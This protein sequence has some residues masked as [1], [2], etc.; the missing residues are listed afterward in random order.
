MGADYRQYPFGKGHHPAGWVETT[1]GDVVLEFRSGYSSGK[2]NQT[3]QGIPHLR[4]MNVSPVG[5]IL[6]EDVRYVSP[7]VRALRLAKND[8]LFTNTSSTAW[9]G[10]TALVQ[11]PGDW[12]F[13]NHMTRLRVADGM[14]PEFVARQL[15]YLCINGY[16]AFHCKKHI[17]QSS[18]AGKQLAENV[19]F[20]LPPANEQKR[21]ASK[22][23]RLLVRE[24]RL[25]EE[26]DALPALIQQ[27]RAA[28]L[29]AACMGR[30][31][32]TE[33]ELARKERREF[34]PASVL[35]ERL[36]VER[37]SKWEVD[38]LAKMRAAG[39][40][41]KDDKWKERYSAPAAS[42][43][44]G[45]SQIPDGWAWAT[46]DG[47][48]E[49]PLCNGISIAGSDKPPGVPALRLS[50]M[51]DSGFNYEDVRYLPLSEAEIDDLW[52]HE[53]DYF[54]SRGSGSPAL[55]GRGTLAQKPP[56]K[57]IFPDTM[58]RLRISRTIRGANWLP[59]IWRSN[60]VRQQ[61]SR[62][63]KTTAGI[64]KIS[65]PTVQTI[66][67]PLPPI[68]EQQRIVAEVEQRLAAIDRIEKQILAALEQTS[69]LRIALFHRSLS[70]KFIP[71]S[72]NDEAA[73]L[74]LEKIT[75]AKKSRLEEQKKEAPK[76]M[77]RKTPIPASRLDLLEV[78]NSHAE[79]L[80]PEELMAE[81]GYA[82]D[83]VP[84]FYQALRKL[85]KEILEVRPERK[86]VIL[87]RR[88]P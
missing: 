65:Q 22:L 47:L 13:S 41:P 67:I 24:R 31:V 50:A 48:I 77:K 16:F 63:A 66:S 71:Q 58:I 53:G 46:V 68:A 44:S 62:R 33:A 17:N 19:P 72:T 36:L 18:V 86:V 7:R 10:K 45:V 12:G 15:H 39:K 25:R 4:P 55:V 52:I 1:V 49:E 70:G 40:E 81:S 14:S 76:A 87:K 83:E 85:E 2:H 3:G 43:L 37:R 27:Y 75:A 11:E 84:A 80:T 9:V 42:H 69:Q 79:G 59:T 51:G 73:S 78:L 29:E 8:V 23:R 20:R 61:V 56:L 74:L 5:E 82:S 34:E 88:R 26:L 38:Q 54:L 57:V 28:V 32:P 35:L 6:M 21:I 64:W 30:L 60:M